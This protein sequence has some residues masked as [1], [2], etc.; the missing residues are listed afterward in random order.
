M[1]LPWIRL[2]HASEEARTSYLGCRTSSGL[3]AMVAEKVLTDHESSVTS[4]ED[5]SITDK[6]METPDLRSSISACSVKE[7]DE[8]ACNISRY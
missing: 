4:I 5:T 2:G 1:R 8:K 3:M 7:R 6:R